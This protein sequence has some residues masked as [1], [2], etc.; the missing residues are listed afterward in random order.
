VKVQFALDHALRDELVD[1]DD[2]DIALE[3]L[4]GH[5]RRGAGT[6]RKLIADPDIH[7]PVP[8]SVLERR[9]ITR[10]KDWGI[11]EP[12]RQWEV[13]DDEGYIGAIDFAWPEQSLALEADGWTHHSK[14]RDWRHDRLR[15]NRLTKGNAGAPRYVGGHSQTGAVASSNSFVLCVVAGALP[16]R[17]QVIHA[18]PRRTADGLSHRLKGGKA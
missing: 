4:G 8:A 3:R 11:P 15:R 9:V 13:W 12:T 6:L 16:G 1:L 18:T 17:S 10:L 14:R 7:L 5:G 2:L